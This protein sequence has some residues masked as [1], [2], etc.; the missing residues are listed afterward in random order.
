MATL[1]PGRA[2]R[3]RVT[4][5]QGARRRL[6]TGPAARTVHRCIAAIGVGPRARGRRRRS[7]VRS[8]SGLA[9]WPSVVS[10]PPSSAVTCA[11][12]TPGLA[13]ARRGWARWAAALDQRRRTACATR[14]GH[15]RR[16]GHGP[17]RRGRRDGGRRAPRSRRRPRRRPAQAGVVSAAA[18]QVSHSVQTVASGTE[19]MGASIKEIAQNAAEAARVADTA[20]GAARATSQTVGLLGTSSKE[21]GDVIKVIDIDRVADQ[22]ARPQRDRS[23]R[24]APARPARASRS[25]PSEV[26][27]P[28]PGDRESH[29]G[30]RSSGRGHPDERHGR[31]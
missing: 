13:T 26:K 20:V 30:H 14:I 17:G 31:G 4:P 24:P 5:Q 2:R 27:R 22:P 6:P 23:R 12:D 15:H 19:Q 9:P 28:R 1:G 18:E 21:I 25:S 7:R 8:S 16:L 3:R 10:P 11:R 29:R